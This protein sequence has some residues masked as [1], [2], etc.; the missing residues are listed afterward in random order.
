MKKQHKIAILAGSAQE[1]FNFKNSVTFPDNVELVIITEG[2]DFRG[3][4]FM[5]YAIVGSFYGR[6][7]ANDILENVKVRVRP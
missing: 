6:E 2:R 1:A 4:E 7:N 3:Y 5:T